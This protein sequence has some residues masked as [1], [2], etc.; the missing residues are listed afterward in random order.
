MGNR[1]VIAYIPS[2]EEVPTDLEAA[3]DAGIVGLYLHWNG[4]PESIQA[5][6]TAAKRYGVR[7][8]DYGLARLTQIIGNY[9]GGTL[10]MGIGPIKSLDTDN[11]DNGTYLVKDWQVVGRWVPEWTDKPY[12]PDP[13]RTAEVYDQVLT[14]NDA[15]FLD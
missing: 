4:G 14:D 13:T 7:P 2:H 1:A 9:L 15:A 10:S 8:D 3:S 12:N 5:F 11:F 6:L